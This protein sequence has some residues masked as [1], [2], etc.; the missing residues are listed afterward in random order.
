MNIIYDIQKLTLTDYPGK[1]ACI[2]FTSGCNFNC[3][4]CQNSSLIKYKA[5]NISS[6]EALEFLN[7]RKTMLDGV[8]I[9]GG[10]PNMW[11]IVDL[12]KNIKDMGYCIKLDTNG[13]QPRYIQHLLSNNL[14]D[15]IAMDIK[16]TYEKYPLITGTKSI[17]RDL[18]Q[19][20]IDIIIYSN[21]NYEFRTTVIDNYHEPE[22]FYIIGDYI[23][24]AKQY[25]LQKFEMKDSVRD[26]FLKEPS[27]EKLKQCA[28]IASTKVNNVQIR[29]IN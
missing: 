20:S 24:G 23:D 19:E 13:T 6:I 26:K 5:G 22:D 21:I 29:G 16:S 18:I 8:V 1:T 10:E 17:D 25:F 2:I 14:I 3:G 4:Y 28:K 27:D 15:Y 11:D 9:S 12:L 7:K